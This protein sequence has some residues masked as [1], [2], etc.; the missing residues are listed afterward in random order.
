M[1]SPSTQNTGHAER[2]L[3]VCEPWSWAESWFP[4]V[5]TMPWDAASTPLLEVSLPSGAGNSQWLLK[6]RNDPGLDCP[7][8]STPL[9]TLQD[10]NDYR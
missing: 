2:S 10:I 1:V 7:F 4:A 5:F 9:L 6:E 3:L 8:P